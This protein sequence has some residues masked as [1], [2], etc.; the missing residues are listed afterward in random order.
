MTRYTSIPILLSLLG[1]LSIT[2]CGDNGSMA[3]PG[4]RNLDRVAQVVARREDRVS[5]SELAHWIIEDKKNFV[6]IDVRSADDYARGHIDGARN[7]PVPELVS[8]EQLKTLPKDRKVIV[9]SQ[10][11]ETAAQAVVLLRLVGYNA[12]LLLGGYNFWSQHVLN[13]DIHPTQADGEYPRVPEQQAIACYFVGGNTVAQAPALVRKPRTP[14]FV[15]PV[16][17]P[18][19]HP[20]PPEFDEGC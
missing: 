5:V 1:T 12:N 7:L 2:A 16:S 20:P 4:I 19:A 3:A 15:P 8:P 14:A 6:L 9:Y 18:A 11:S 17:Q 13:P 10:G